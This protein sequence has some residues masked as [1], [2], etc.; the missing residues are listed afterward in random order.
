M[1]RKFFQDWFNSAMKRAPITLA[2]VKIQRA[3][4]IIQ[5]KHGFTNILAKAVHGQELEEIETYVR[6]ARHGRI[7]AHTFT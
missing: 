7:L 6:D 2:C 4:R 3:Q 1:R 5:L